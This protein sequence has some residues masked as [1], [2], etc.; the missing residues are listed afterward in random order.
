MGDAALRILGA[1]LLS[2]AGRQRD[3]VVARLREGRSAAKEIALPDLGMGG[4]FLFCPVA[5]DLPPQRVDA[6]VEAAVADALAAA[7]LNAEQRRR[8]P[9][10]V[11][12]S[13]MDV[14]IGEDAAQTLAPSDPL[15]ARQDGWGAIA[16][17][18]ATRFGLRDRRFSFNAACNSA[19]NALLAAMEQLAAG[20][21]ERALVVGVECRNQLSLHGF[22]SLLLLSQDACRP[23]DR[24]RSGMVLGEGAAAVV[25]A[26]GET[27]PRL[28]GGAN[29]SDGGNVTLPSPDAMVAAMS[30]ALVAARTPPEAITAVKAHGTATPSNDAA[31]GEALRRLFGAALPPLTSLKPQLGYTLG[32]NVLLELVAWLWCLEA[33]FVAPTPNFRQP[34]PEVG[35]T[36]LSAP[37]PVRGGR[38]LLNCFGFGGNNTCLVLAHD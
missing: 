1:G 9:V 17:R 12:S 13:S 26:R 4:R 35:F 25:L 36:P 21:C 24:E 16:D 15:L 18:L 38:F 37:L 30:A 19:A 14:A 7:H 8:M 22:N 6:M 20:R 23:F 2:A 29:R 11:G 34:D 28:L 10:F 27:G 32:A 31:E 3:T 5:A 33:G